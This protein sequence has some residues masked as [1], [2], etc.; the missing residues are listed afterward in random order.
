MVGK[1][2]SNSIYNV[3]IKRN[4]IGCEEDR[5]IDRVSIR[6]NGGNGLIDRGEEGGKE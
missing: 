3:K 6:E 2:S 5:R 4:R 1:N